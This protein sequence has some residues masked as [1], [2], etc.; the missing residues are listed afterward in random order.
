MVGQ[1]AVWVQE[2]AQI[3][4]V[5]T[6]EALVSEFL[7]L[8]DASHWLERNASRILRTR[9]SPWWASPNWMMGN[10]LQ[11]RRRP[12]GK[13]LIVA[14]G[15]YPLFL[16]G[17]QL[18]QALAAGNSVWLKPPPG[19]EAPLRRLLECLEAP[20]AVTLLGSSPEEVE[21]ALEAEMDLVVLTGSEATGRQL[22]PRLGA[23]LLPS[24]AE[25]SGQ[26]VVLVGPGADLDL[27][28]RAIE[29]GQ[30]L[31]LG[32]TC[33]RPQRLWLGPGQ[34][35]ESDL[36]VR[37]YQGMDQL[38]GWLASERGLGISIFASSQWFAEILPHC[39]TGY[40]CHNDLIAPTAHPDAPFGGRGTSG[41]GVTRGAE[42]LLA[43]TYPQSIL[44]HRGPHFHLWP[45]TPATEPLLQAYTDWSHG[46]GWQRGLNLA[47]MAWHGLRIGLGGGFRRTGTE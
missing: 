9:H 16:A 44:V 5:D 2:L 14:P 33:M 12:W 19:K 36:E 20:Q 13:V 29:W 43:L 27:V 6:K 11:V 25:L 40:V 1:R 41:Y 42:G 37:R 46:S 26:D 45:T 23:R 39:R 21:R 30:Q 10:Q 38:K 35:L 8:L 18:L 17:V 22:M 7:P 4:G 31:N 28:A 3:R 47:K 24:I 34:A 15:N 32:A